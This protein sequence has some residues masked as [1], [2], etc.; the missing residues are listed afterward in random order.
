MIRNSLSGSDITVPEK[1]G[2]GVSVLINSKYDYFH[3]WMSY[4]AWYSLQRNLPGAKVALAVPRRGLDL[5]LYHWAYRC[6][7]RFMMYRNV[8]KMNKMFAV[9]LALKRNL[10]RQPLIVMD[11]DVMALGELELPSVDF[12]VDDNVWYF[13]NQ[14]VEKFE[15]A[16]N[17]GG[18]VSLFGDGP[19]FGSTFANYR[20]KCG[21]FLKKNWLRGKV[22]PPFNAGD[23]FRSHDLS[24]EESKI[25]DLWNQMGDM[26]DFLNQV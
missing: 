18:D 23:A 10:V 21:N 7:I 24:L 2:T 8:E 19:V 9:Y 4:A 11:A 20:W 16:I 26:Y 14:P 6:D 5:M 22:K 3:N 25:I 13:N 17:K 1:D 12:A 15:E